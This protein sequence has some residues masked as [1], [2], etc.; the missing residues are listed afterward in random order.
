MAQKGQK[1]HKV[2]MCKSSLLRQKKM[3]LQHNPGSGCRS[4]DNKKHACPP[5][6]GVQAVCLG[7]NPSPYFIYYDTPN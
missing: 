2:S 1:Q 5:L 6:A 3:N 7:F 4:K